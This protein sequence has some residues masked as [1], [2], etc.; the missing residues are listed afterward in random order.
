MITLLDTNV[1]YL[2]PSRADESLGSGTVM[3]PLRISNA[4]Q[5]RRLLLSFGP[6]TTFMLYPGLYHVEPTNIFADLGT[7]LKIKRGWRFQGMGPGVILK[8]DWAGLPSGSYALFSGD[9]KADGVQVR[10]LT[11]D[12]DFASAPA[13]ISAGAYSVH[14]DDQ[15]VDRVNVVNWGGSLAGRETFVMA[16]RGDRCLFERVNVGQPVKLD[17]GA[18]IMGT[19]G[20][21]SEQG[22]NSFTIQNCHVDG[23][24]ADGPYIVGIGAYGRNATVRNN[25]I[26]RVL[27]GTYSDSGKQGQSVIEGNYYDEVR[28]GVYVDLTPNAS[29]RELLIRNNQIELSPFQA[30]NC[31]G[32]NT[33]VREPLVP[34]RIG[35]LRAEGNV[36]RF[37]P[38]ATKQVGFGLRCVGVETLCVVN[39]MVDK[40]IAKPLTFSRCGAARFYINL[41]SDMSPA[42]QEGF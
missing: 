30:G 13:R 34:Y 39:N 33:L 7:N 10:D 11:I 8:A 18:T 38:N 36:I 32:I 24:Y 29:V 26:Q 5:F 40:A 41:R 14:G 1:V 16:A 17:V 35:H 6:D 37:H 23:G 31:S 21:E 25:W 22:N 4:Y 19:P 12:M 3:D 27:Y 28:M 42:Y 20:P 15:I 2:I 9:G